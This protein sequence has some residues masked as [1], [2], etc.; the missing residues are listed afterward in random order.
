MRILIAADIFPP[1]GGGPA[2]YAAGLAN[3][4][5]AAGD[6][7]RVV[8]LTPN[9]DKAVV[10]CPLFSVRYRGIFRYLEYLGLLFRFVKDN[11]AVYA[12]GPVNAGLPAWFAARLFGKKFIV[13]VVGDYAWEQGVQRAGVKELVDEFQTKKYSGIVGVWQKIERLIVRQA[14]QVIVPSRYLQ[15]IVM[16]W[17]AQAKK[18]QVIYNAVAFV[19]SGNLVVQKPTGELWITTLARLVPWKGIPALVNVFKKISFDFPDTRL[20]IIG[21]GPERATLETM[22]VN[23]KLQNRVE[24]LGNIPN[25]IVHEYLKKSE[26]FVLNSGYEGLSHVLVEALHANC[27]VLA[28][29]VGGNPEIIIPQETGVLFPYNDE[30]VLEKELREAMIV[31][32]TRPFSNTISRSEFFQKFDFGKMIEETRTLLQKLCAH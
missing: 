32:Q 13:K 2:I 28:S 10:D 4:L 27:R 29:A 17:G 23:A 5:T 16:G 20:K 18:I 30:V 6:T 7:V 8:S 3:A 24:F 11:D 25:E 21:D 22:V 12:M 31:R 26:I 1:L 19:D 14:D 15:K 9:S